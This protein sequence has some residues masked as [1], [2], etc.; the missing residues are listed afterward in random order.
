[1]DKSIYFLFLSINL[2]FRKI[3]ETNVRVLT[4]VVTSKSNEQI[5]VAAILTTVP[6][7][8]NIQGNR[9]G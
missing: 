5:V 9:Y 1:M 8:V 6:E 4:S 7:T 2:F 3:G